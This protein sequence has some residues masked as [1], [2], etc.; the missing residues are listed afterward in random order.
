MSRVLLAVCTI[1]LAA[2]G[3]GTREAGKVYTPA[4]FIGAQFW[5]YTPPEA[6]GPHYV[7]LP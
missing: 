4:D 3:G 1:T 5:Y 6:R 2:C 7:P